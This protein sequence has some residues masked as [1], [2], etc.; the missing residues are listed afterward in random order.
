MISSQ[1][2]LKEALKAL[3]APK[4]PRVV[5]RIFH[6]AQQAQFRHLTKH[7]KQQA[8]LDAALQHKRY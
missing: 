8:E 3:T 5:K 7:E 2:H 4:D 1:K 6:D